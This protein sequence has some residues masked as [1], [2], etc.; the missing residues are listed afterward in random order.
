MMTGEMNKSLLLTLLCFA[1]GWIKPIAA[2]VDCDDRSEYTKSSSKI[3]ADI[4]IQFQ[5]GTRQDI[6]D[7][8]FLFELANAI[9]IAYDKVAGTVC[10]SCRR[11]IDSVALLTQDDPNYVGFQSAPYVIVQVEVSQAGGCSSVFDSR[12]QD[13]MSIA[14]TDEFVSNCTRFTTTVPDLPTGNACCNAC[15]GVTGVVSTIDF[16]DQ[17]AFDMGLYDAGNDDNYYYYADDPYYSNA[18]LTRQTVPPIVREME[19]FPSWCSTSQQQTT[20][21][22][23][24]GS[25]SG[26]LPNAYQSIFGYFIATYNL[27]TV[28]ECYA[29]R[30]LAIDVVGDF[31]FGNATV[32]HRQLQNATFGVPC[33]DQITC[34]QIDIQKRCNS[35]ACPL[36]DDAQFCQLFDACGSFAPSS[37]QPTAS[38]RQ[39]DLA[40]TKNQQ[41]K[42]IGSGFDS[43][44]VESGSNPDSVESFV[45]QL[46]N[47]QYFADECAC[48]L[49]YGDGG[50][51]NQ[52]PNLGVFLSDL[53]FGLA[54]LFDIGAV[55]LYEPV[56]SCQPITFSCSAFAGGAM[57]MVFNVSVD[58]SQTFLTEE[59]IV[60]LLIDWVPQAYDV[61]AG[62]VCDPCARR[63]VVF[64]VGWVPGSYEFEVSVSVEQTGSCFDIF[65]TSADIT[66]LDERFSFET[67]CGAF[68]DLGNCCCGRT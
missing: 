23:Y 7:I 39:R 17:L 3:F 41:P 12:T 61:V 31:G 38:P 54:S 50:F 35:W 30:L 34:L 21:T 56:E 43:G 20:T 11:N 65:D 27:M 16:A 26:I 68:H 49:S 14:D 46:H 9:P 58:G 63:L 53:N 4:L 48:A 37:S 59:E 45:R 52:L 32:R 29:Q 22:L 1:G 19:S 15:A 57:D 44:S 8:D 40:E 6:D 33:A 60:E 62:T 13:E 64:G 66:T 51:A 24:L 55:D 47:D 25:N 18:A 36:V 67:T 42:D 10:D 28:E 5:E 2:Q